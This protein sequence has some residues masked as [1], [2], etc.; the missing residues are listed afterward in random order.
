MARFDPTAPIANETIQGN[1]IRDLAVGR[2]ATSVLPK[3]RGVARAVSRRIER[4][5]RSHQEPH[6]MR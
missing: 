1:V 4:H 3:R 6:L 5:E 2:W